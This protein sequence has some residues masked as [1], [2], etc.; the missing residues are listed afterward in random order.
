MKKTIIRKTK[1]IKL[2]GLIMFKQII[3][4]LIV[5]IFFSCKTI[6]IE[7]IGIP[8]EFTDRDLYLG[9]ELEE[10]EA[11]TNIVN[12]SSVGYYQNLENSYFDIIYFRFSGEKLS[13]IILEKRVQSD[14]Y[15]IDSNIKEIVSII[16]K[17]YGDI[18]V[19]GEL[20]TNKKINAKNPIL[21]WRLEKDYVASLVYMP[22]FVYNDLK[23]KQKS[24]PLNIIFEI[25]KDASFQKSIFF[26]EEKLNLLNH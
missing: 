10:I 20:I 3:T 25:N 17:Y 16:K 11:D 6:Q 15:P 12:D 5:S 1:I 9:M 14:Q 4:V 23:T 8:L 26:T 22:T 18:S 13:S 24:L 19:I 7:K 2:L 21:V